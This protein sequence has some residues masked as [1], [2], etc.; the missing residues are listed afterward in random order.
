MKLSV[1]IELREHKS[2]HGANYNNGGCVRHIFR[3]PS[4]SYSQHS[5]AMLCTYLPLI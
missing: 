4:G 3:Q 2:G 5:V 1:V